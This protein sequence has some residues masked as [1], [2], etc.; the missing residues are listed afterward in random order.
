MKLLIENCEVVA[1]MDDA[2]TELR[3]GSILID[4]GVIAWVGTGEPPAEAEGAQRIDG[5]DAVAIPGLVNTHHHLCQ[6]LTRVRAQ[7]EDIFGW[8]KTLYPVWANLDADWVHAGANAALAEM[9]LS[10]CTLT[11]DHHYAFPE[12]TTGLIEAEIEAARRLGIRFQPNRGS[13]DLGERDGGLPPQVLCEDPDEALARTE[14]IVRR[15][16]DPSEGSMLRVSIGPCYPLTNSGRLMTESA[17]LARRLGVRLHTHIAEGRD[18]EASMVEHFGHRPLDLLETYGYVGDD[19]WLAHCVQLGDQD[20]DKLART[21][22]G[23]ATCPS[24]NMRL[25]SGRAP[26]RRM[27]DRGVDVGLGVDGSA[28]NDSNSVIGEAR[29]LLLVQRVE[30]FEHALTAREA[31]RVATRGGAA[32]LGRDDVGSLEVGKRADVVLFPL[33]DLAMIGTDYDPLAAL[34][35]CTPPRPRH[36]LIEGR[37][38]VRDGRLAT[39]DED[40]IVREARAATRRVMELAGDAAPAAS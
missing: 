1:T 12:G 3:G 23:V 20:I 14:D 32:V 33:D 17:E 5:R 38:V 35:F 21:G 6:V 28:S 10:G 2:G 30:G 19:V 36:V 15:Y 31:L 16:H 13:M 26:I 9:V 4:D 39:V 18:E 40:E 27:L 34:V 8:L 25:G 22:T 29:Q 37:H 11:T 24:S 7:E